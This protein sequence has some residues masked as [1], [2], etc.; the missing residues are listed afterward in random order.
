MRLLC[1]PEY[2]NTINID[3]F[4]RTKILENVPNVCAEYQAKQQRHGVNGASIPAL[5]LCHCTETW[6]GQLMGASD[7]SE[8]HMEVVNSF[9]THPFFSDSPSALNTH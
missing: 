8:P 3:D 5:L 4:L 6:L 1:L 9:L 2:I 7:S